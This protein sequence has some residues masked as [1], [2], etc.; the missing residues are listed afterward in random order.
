[1]KSRKTG[2]VTFVVVQS[3]TAGLGQWAGES[4]DVVEDYKTIY[5]EEP[6]NPHAI[7]LSIDTNDTHSTAE[8]LFGRIAFSSR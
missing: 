4:R 5:G 7:A 3:G 6:A 2:T 1:V 8:A